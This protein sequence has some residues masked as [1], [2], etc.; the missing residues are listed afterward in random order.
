MTRARLTQE[1]RAFL[2]FVEAVHDLS[3]DPAP[4]T[5][6]R[7]LAASSA[8]EESRRVAPTPSQ[9]RAKSSRAAER[10]SRRPVA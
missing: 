3:Y 7:Y 9:A 4:A 2:Q 8:L 1:R 5:L 6:E 10:R